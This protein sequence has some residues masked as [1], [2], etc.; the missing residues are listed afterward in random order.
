MGQD[1]DIAN[2]PALGLAFIAG[3]F[4]IAVQQAIDEGAQ[5][6]SRVSAMTANSLT[7][8]FIA[9]AMRRRAIRKSSYVE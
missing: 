3:K 9:A 1:I 8:S 5:I 6:I 7:P 2:G 4:I